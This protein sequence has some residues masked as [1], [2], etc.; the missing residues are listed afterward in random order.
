MSSDPRLMIH[1]VAVRNNANLVLDFIKRSVSIRNNKVILKLSIDPVKPQLDHN[2][3]FGFH[4][5][6]KDIEAL[7]SVQREI[8]QMIPG[9]KNIYI[10]IF[11]RAIEI[12]R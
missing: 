5:Y 2:V 4:Y 12:A 3:Q 10:Y 8:T 9:L 1:F 6:R 11:V 7:E